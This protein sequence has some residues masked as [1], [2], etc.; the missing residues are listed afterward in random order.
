MITIDKELKKQLKE[1]YKDEQVLVVQTDSVKWMVD[2]F[3]PIDKNEYLVLSDMQLNGRYIYR[4]DAEYNNAFQQVIPYCVI[5]NKDKTKFFINQRKAGE[6]RLTG[7]NSM[8]FGGHI[9]PCDGLQNSIINGLWR[10]LSEEVELP[11]HSKEKHIGYV[12]D[13]S[14][15]LTDHIGIIFEVTSSDMRLTKI[16]ET[17]S[18]EG[19]WVT[20]DELVDNY[21]LFEGW[22]RYLID[23]YF[24]LK[25]KN[26]K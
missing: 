19:K 22:S 24:E 26:K 15:K 9:N 18:M 1:K 10:E 20:L 13:L 6:S 12:R 16:K 3:T 5:I 11:P 21:Y 7:M 2:K 25:N 23:Y 14:S 17:E 4:C 8:G